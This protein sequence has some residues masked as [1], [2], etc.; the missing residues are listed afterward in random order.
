MQQTYNWEGHP[1]CHPSQATKKGDL[2]ISPDRAAG[3]LAAERG[4]YEQRTAGQ[5]AG[6]GWNKEGQVCGV[7][8]LELYAMHSGETW[9]IDLFIH[10]SQLTSHAPIRNDRRRTCFTTKRKVMVVYWKAPL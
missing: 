9:W 3:A 7:K 8:A 2:G 6:G 4:A 1:T 10:K 5:G